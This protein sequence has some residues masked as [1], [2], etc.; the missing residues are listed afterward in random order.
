MAP[1]DDQPLVS[2][3]TPVFN[4][5]P[6]LAECI[7]SVLAQTHSNWHYTIVNNRS[8]DGT[9]EIANRYAQKDPRIRVVTND[10]FYR[11]SEN[12]NVAFRLMPPEAK[13]CKVV[14]ADDWIFPECLSELV[15]IAEKHPSVGLVG[16][17]GLRGTRLAWDGLAYSSTV[18]NGRELGRS[19]ML[20]GP[21]V[22][23]TATS[24]LFRADCVR[25]RHAFF[26]EDN[27]HA[28]TGACYDVLSDS[29]FAFV[30]KVLSF[31]RTENDGLTSVSKRLNTYMPGILNDLVIFGPTYL[32]PEEQTH[33]VEK[34]LRLYYR[35]LARSAFDGRWDGEFW[36]YHS[37]RLRDL[38]H[39]LNRR[40]LAREFGWIAFD[41]ALA[42]NRWP[43]GL[44]NRVRTLVRRRK[45]DASLTPLRPLTNA[46]S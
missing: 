39:S 20:G 28:D 33:A 12:H 15:A 25:R 36:R 2:V 27:I 11:V 19:T 34:H 8:T 9:L 23:G 38:G 44:V 42:F 24:I 6:Y 13:Y 41:T 5:E 3:L 16:A 1:R 40:R 35:F 14:L 30:H 45:S 21:Y 17:Y 7:E 10:R 22:F 18:I 37:R 43:K 4:G 46:K 26:N 29:D 32:S 31:T